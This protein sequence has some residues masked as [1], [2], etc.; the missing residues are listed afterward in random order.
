MENLTRR[1]VIQG[2]CALFAASFVGLPEAANA[3]VKRIA[4][5]RLS[6]RVKLIP[7]LSEIGGAV[8]IGNFK[9]KPAGLARTGTDTYVAFSL[10]CPHQGVTVER[11]DKGWVCPAHMSEFESD[12]DLVL[13]PATRR[14]PRIPS[15]FS[16]GRVIVG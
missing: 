12:G 1:S 10:A 2:A 7:E 9:G 8:Q 16:N 4:N 11:S 13:G 5:G 14:L 3:S 6:V 15:R